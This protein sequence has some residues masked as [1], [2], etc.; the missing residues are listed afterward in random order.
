M[1]VLGAATA[2]VMTL[3]I[4]A[5]ASAAVTF[6]GGYIQ[7]NGY[8]YA[9]G[10]TGFT[11][12]NGSGYAG[13]YTYLT[14]APEDAGVAGY[15]YAA[16]VHRASKT[17]PVVTDAWA[18]ID[19]YGEVLLTDAANG[20]IAF[21]TDTSA[22]VLPGATA[23]ASA[24]AYDY[25]SYFYYD[26]S[27]DE[28]S[29]LTFNW[30]TSNSNTSLYNYVQ[31]YDYNYG[32][33]YSAYLD[34]NDIGSFVQTLSNIGQYQLYIQN[35]YNYGGYVSQSAVGISSGFRDDLYSFSIESAVPE[36]MTWALMI[37]GFGMTGAAL[38]RR[39]VAAAVA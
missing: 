6:V 21:M 34:G 30:S 31:L 2:A 13:D 32:T 33:L 12:S 14:G 22:E 39:R 36:P 24:E 37:A 4:T 19:L 3:A 18:S 27:I 35:Y 15:A 23:G 10:G 11:S 7:T 26:F 5:P 1:R 25:S 29:D 17:S 8:A 20:S 28:V 9:H 38:R 16:G